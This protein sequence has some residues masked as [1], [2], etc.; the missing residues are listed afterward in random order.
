MKHNVRF[1][2]L[3]NQTFGYLTVISFDGIRNKHTYWLC[4]CCCG[5]QRSLQT[6]RLTTNKVTSCG[7]MNPR[8]QKSMVISSHKR[9]YSVY[10]SMLSRCENPKSISYKYYGERG[11]TICDEWHDYAVFKEWALA[12]GYND[13]LSIDR[14]D[15]N[16]GYSPDNCRWIPLGDQHK[17]QSNNI[18]ITHNG[19]THIL[20][21]WCDILN[22]P[23]QTVKDRRKYAKSTGRELT[24]EQMFSPP[25]ISAYNN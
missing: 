23:Y 4:R 9:L 25:R 11:V 21:E 18:L 16:K 7:C 2:D 1:K 8:T 17:N 5:K 10:S 19:E 24:F 6:S 15:N 13:T 3:S 22:I 14:I 20:K 12:N